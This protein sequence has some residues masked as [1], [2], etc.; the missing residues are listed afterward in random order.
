MTGLLDSSLISLMLCETL[1]SIRFLVRC[2]GET[3]KYQIEQ[4]IEKT[5]Q[6]NKV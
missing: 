3:L 1:S 6:I 4:N 2:L 5:R